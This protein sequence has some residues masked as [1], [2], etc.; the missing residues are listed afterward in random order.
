[1][2]LG[3]IVISPC[4]FRFKGWVSLRSWTTRLRGKWT[5]SR[6]V[7]WP[8]MSSSYISFLTQAH[9]SI[10]VDLLPWLVCVSFP[11]WSGCFS[12]FNHSNHIF[13]HFPILQPHGIHN[14]HQLSPPYTFATL[15]SS[16]Q[17][18][19]KVYALRSIVP[20]KTSMHIH[21]YIFI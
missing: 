14:E 2:T 5:Y 17:L 3:R 10:F 6:P 20:A 1:M 16:V 15:G 12:L 7:L 21:V 8:K 13:G 11:N 18:Q 19:D 9:P 4:A